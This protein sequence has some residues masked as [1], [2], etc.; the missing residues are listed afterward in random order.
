M[1]VKTEKTR[2][3][4]VALALGMALGLLVL[5]LSRGQARA[6][7]P[8][9]G[10]S[11]QSVF[12]QPAAAGGASMFAADSPFDESPLSISGSTIEMDYCYQ[13]DKTQTF[14]FTV[15]NGSPD[16]EWINGVTLTFPDDPSPTIPPWSVSGCTHEDP[17]DSQ[18][19]PVN[20][21]CTPSGNQVFYTDTDGDGY[22]EISNGASWMAC[23]DV[24]VPPEYSIGGLRYIPWELYGDA[25]GSVTG[26]RIEV[27]MCTPLRLMPSQVVI[28]GC[29]GLAQSL[30]F[31]LTNYSAGND[32][33]VNFIYDAPDAEF[34]GPTDVQLSEGGTVTFTAEFKP[35]LCIEPGETVTGSLTV[36][37]GVHSDSSFITQSIAENAGWRRRADSDIPTMDSVVIWA[38]RED[39]VPGDEGLWSIGGFG[40]DGAV[41]RYDPDS[42]TWRKD[43]ESEAVITPLIEYPMD[44]CY[45]LNGTGEEIIVLFPDTIVTGSLHVYNLTQ[46]A[47]STLPTPTGYP[48]EGRWGHDVVSMLQHTDENVCYLSGG[49]TQ[50]GGGRTRDLWEYH[51]DTNTVFD[52]SPFPASVWFGFHA[53]WYVPWIGGA[54][55]AICV[56]GGVDYN[57]IINQSTQCF[58]RSSGTFGGLNA[59]LGELPELWWGMAD[60]WQ[61]TDEG[62][63]LWIANGV[64]SDGT[65]L[66]VS[67]YFR[68]GMPPAGGFQYGP[69]IP[70]GM[71]RLEG[72][73]WN[74]QFYTLNG[75][76]GGFWYSEFSLH[77]SFCPACNEVFLPLSLRDH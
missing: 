4:V 56:A 2:W 43:F 75:S 53:S 61:I 23:I 73:A 34:T 59:D 37:G 70:H 16:G 63:E 40:S 49:S 17:T 31:E 52:H 36:E 76:R 54:D 44:G 35:N 6:G 33:T 7:D 42:D 13:A 15:Y 62:Y 45:G 46:D 19:Y 64:A 41:Q 51:P 27:E 60:G 1:N 28:T 38:H 47:W 25:G 66:P 18:G 26:E 8:G 5:I 67:A 65:L 32:T 71:Y 30:E 24:Y 22:G 50:T 12:A 55:G 58:Y 68:E 21:T 72:D 14:C 77:L 29:N 57:H 3:L 39:G 20:F 9:S 11:P 48:V 69:P 74:D 10:R